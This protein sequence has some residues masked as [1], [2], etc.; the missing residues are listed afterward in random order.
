METAGLLTAG[1]TYGGEEPRRLC[2]LI[3]LARA[4]SSLG[5]FEDGYAA[6]R[7]RSGMQ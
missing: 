4:W 5:N 1:A 2:P 3:G 7:T 6:A